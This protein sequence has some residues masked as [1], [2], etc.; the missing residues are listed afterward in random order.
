[1]PA[2]TQD[3]PYKVAIPLPIVIGNTWRLDLTLEDY[4][5]ATQIATPFDLTGVTGVAKIREQP[6]GRVVATPTVALTSAT[7]GELS[8]TLDAATTALLVPEHELL[9][10]V[11][12]TWPTGEVYDIIEARVPIRRG[13]VS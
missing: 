5:D 1:M 13:L 10:G 2:Y 4:D 12:L 3:E 9:M 7:D 11:R 8:V 6:S